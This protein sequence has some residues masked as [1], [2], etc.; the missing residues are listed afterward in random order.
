MYVT[1]VTH[2]ATTRRFARL[3]QVIGGPGTATVA[4]PVVHTVLP[5]RRRPGH[6]SCPGRFLVSRSLAPAQIDWRVP[7]SGPKG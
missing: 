5:C 3:P 7:V 6:R 1:D 4:G 2:L